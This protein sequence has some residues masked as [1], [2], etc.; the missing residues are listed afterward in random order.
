M[1]PLSYDKIRTRLALEKQLESIVTAAALMADADCTRDERTNR[2]VAECN[3]VREALQ[4]LLDKYMDNVG[5]FCYI[6]NLAIM[7]IDCLS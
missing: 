1:D 7:M 2:I 6:Q 3:A 5:V 4:H